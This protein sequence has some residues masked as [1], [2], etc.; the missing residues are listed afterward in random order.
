[1]P[2]SSRADLGQACDIGSPCRRLAALHSENRRLREAILHGHHVRGQ[3]LQVLDKTL[4][5]LAKQNTR[6]TAALDNMVQGL[7]MFDADHRIAVLNRLFTEFFSVT[8]TAR[9]LNAGPDR[10][11]ECLVQS[12]SL[13]SAIAEGLLHFARGDR[14]RCRCDDVRPVGW[15]LSGCDTKRRSGW[16]VA[17]HVRRYNR[18]EKGRGSA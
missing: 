16:R 1:M 8:D 11:Q 9:L 12:G 18:P 13:T 6:F 10:L 15:T 3:S 5:D 4:D 7:C 2:E 17:D 14:K